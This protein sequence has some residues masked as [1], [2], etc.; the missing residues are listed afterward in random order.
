VSNQ[1]QPKD[2]A[3]APSYCTGVIMIFSG[4][5]IRTSVSGEICEK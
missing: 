4:S 3:D 2:T 5:I 1:A